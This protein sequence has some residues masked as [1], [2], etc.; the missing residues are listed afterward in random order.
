MKPW[1]RL[2]SHTGFLVYRQ[3][4]NTRAGAPCRDIRHLVHQPLEPGPAPPLVL[5]GQDDAEVLGQPTERLDIAPYQLGCPM[6]VVVYRVYP[7]RNR[8]VGLA[9]TDVYREEN[10][11]EGEDENVV[12]APEKAAY[13]ESRFLLFPCV[14][15]ARFGS[16]SR[17]GPGRW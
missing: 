15:R 5:E 6:V 16:C 9:D 2:L 17:S 14:G 8:M 4:R 7:V 11:D 1:H 10:V 3:L 12:L 13:T